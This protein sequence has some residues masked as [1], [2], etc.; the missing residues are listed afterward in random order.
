[1]LSYSLH[2]K[3]SGS[4]ELLID[5]RGA[6][7]PAGYSTPN[8]L[9][10]VLG[11]TASGKTLLLRCLAGQPITKPLHATGHVIFAGNSRARQLTSFVPQTPSLLPVLS[12]RETLEDAARIRLSTFLSVDEQHRRVDAVL[13]ALK[14]DR[15]QHTR[16][17]GGLSGG[18]LQRLSVAVELIS[19]PQWII[20]DEATSA[21]SA[22]DSALLILCLSALSRKTGVIFSLHQP[23]P[24]IFCCLDSVTLLT[25]GRV[26][27]SGPPEAALPHV[28][29]VRRSLGIGVAPFPSATGADAVLDALAVNHDLSGADNNTSALAATLLVPEQALQIAAVWSSEHLL[30]EINIPVDARPFKPD[31]RALSPITH[32]AATRAFRYVWRDASILGALFGEEVV[33]VLL[34]AAIYAPLGHGQASVA[35]RRGLLFFVV[36]ELLFP[37]FFLSMQFYFTYS[38][39]W[40][41][42]DGIDQRARYLLAAFFGQLLADLPLVLLLPPVF[43]LPAYYLVGLRPAFGAF[44]LFQVIMILASAAGLS[45]AYLVAYCSKD[46]VTASVLSPTLLILLFLLAGLYQNVNAA[47]AIVKWVGTISSVRWVF[48]AA[49]I[50]EFAGLIFDCRPEEEVNGQCPIPDGDTALRQSGFDAVGVGGSIAFATLA[51]LAQ[52]VLAG[53]LLAFRARKSPWKSVETGD[54]TVVR[55]LKP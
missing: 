48:Q 33:F 37:L 46:L 21:M 55:F 5:A 47:P 7:P 13:D 54:Q 27:F 29:C 30:P 28:Q 32:V 6:F 41:A 24:E 39:E 42:R 3:A 35:D 10:G 51:I 38:R 23:R 11:Q 12:A 52:Y 44:A 15:C 31:A 2:V 36:S 22:I 45:L 34:V 16:V 53:L 40:Y 9:H 1:M 17:G 4:E 18:E 25:E 19:D 14:L 43:G 26:A 8:G 20:L 49:S 50:N